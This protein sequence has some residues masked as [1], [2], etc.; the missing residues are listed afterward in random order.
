MLTQEKHEILIDILLYYVNTYEPVEPIEHVYNELI[1]NNVEV[2]G[3]SFFCPVIKGG[4]IV[5]LAGTKQSADTWVLK[6]I[7]KLIKSGK[8]I[9]TFFN[10]NSDHL[11]QK[12][13]RYN[14]KIIERKNDMSII[15]FNAV[16]E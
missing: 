15:S 9:I 6:K 10:G 3:S 4:K 14:I 2:E 13:S 1:S 7:I 11:L 16:S 8:E 12:F 5:L